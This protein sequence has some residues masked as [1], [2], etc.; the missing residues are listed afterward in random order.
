MNEEALKSKVMIAAKT[1]GVPFNSAFHSLVMERFLARLASSS[2]SESFIFKGGFLL[3]R[4]V[5][6][7]RET[8]DLDFLVRFIKAEKETIFRALTEISARNLGDGFL[9]SIKNIQDLI[10]D[11]MKHSGFTAKLDV[12]LGKMRETLDI[13]IGVGDA[14]NPIKKSF[15]MLRSKDKP[16]FESDISL[17]VYPAQT[18]LAEKIHTAAQR[19]AQNSRMKDYFDIWKLLPLMEDQ[20]PEFA[21]ALTATFATRETPLDRLPLDFSEEQTEQ[22]QKLWKSF[23]R[24][25]SN[26]DN[27]PGRIS[28]VILGLNTFLV[29][30]LGKN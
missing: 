21:I 24:N 6:L 9:F 3:S 13:D 26:K 2:H 7:G 23:F 8:K 14:V 18:I 29:G 1:L 5:D 30:V 10:H 4:Y 19:G 22:L 17:H 20:K 16:I 15:H 12:T 11:H 27:I 25:L 28:E